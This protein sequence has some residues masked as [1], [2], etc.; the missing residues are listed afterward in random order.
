MMSECEPGEEASKPR[1]QRC[2]SSLDLPLPLSLLQL[3]TSRR[4]LSHRQET[5]LEQCA[6]L[7][8]FFF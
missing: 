2:S 4:V 5:I 8:F 7:L 1:K 6:F 3:L